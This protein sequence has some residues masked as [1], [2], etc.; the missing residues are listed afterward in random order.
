MEEIFSAGFCLSHDQEMIQ[1]PASQLSIA[2][3]VSRPWDL[4]GL[5]ETDP[6]L[7]IPMTSLTPISSSI[8]QIPQSGSLFLGPDDHLALKINR[9]SFALSQTL[10]DPDCSLPALLL[11][12]ISKERM[13]MHFASTVSFQH[14][15]AEQYSAISLFHFQEGFDPLRTAVIEGNDDDKILTLSSFHF[16]FVF[17]LE[18]DISLHTPEALSLWSVD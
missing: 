8:S 15:S 7:G 18:G 14:I 6:L 9:T 16:P 4:V 13:A 3:I 5:S 10:K 2:N 1:S 12:S 11:Q 17:K